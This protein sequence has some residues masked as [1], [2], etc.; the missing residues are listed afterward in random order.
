MYDADDERVWSFQTPVNGLS[1]F[2]RWT[3]RGLDGKVRRTFELYGYAWG[4]AWG[5]SNLWED[6]TYRDG[7]LL[8]S[9]RSNGQQRHMDVDHLGT[10]RLIT[11]YGSNQNAYHVYL[12][13]GVEATYFAQDVERMKFT[14]HERDLADPSSP[15]DDLDYMHARHYSMITGRFLSFDPFGGNLFK[16]QSWNRYSYALGNPVRYVD[17]MGLFPCGDNGEFNC[18]DSITVIGVDPWRGTTQDPLTGLQ[19]LN[20]LV[21]GHDA[22]ANLAAGDPEFAR[23]ALGTAGALAE[24]A[25]N[26]V[27]NFL[28]YLALFTPGFGEAEAVSL[29]LGS[30]GAVDTLGIS[31]LTKQ[32]G[33]LVEGHTVVGTETAGKSVF[34]AGENVVQLIKSASGATPVPQQGG[35]TLAFVVDAGRVIGTDVRTGAATSTYTVITDRARNLVTAFPGLPWRW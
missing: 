13:Y 22:L 20:N 32:L 27:T 11:N 5:G 12:P 4:N 35:R 16:P 9:Y 14:G 34:A 1:R 18:D 8:A 19:G 17:P 31:V 6:Q 2:D 25:G 23:V 24:G 7:T 33:H 28:T 3:L 30:T 26:L 10:P 15:A 29:G 21:A